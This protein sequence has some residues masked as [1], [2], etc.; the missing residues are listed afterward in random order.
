MDR[1]MIKKMKRYVDKSFDYHLFYEELEV[2][3]SC[4]GLG[5]KVY[6]Q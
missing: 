1:P 2:K 6:N 5:N 3:C 4:N